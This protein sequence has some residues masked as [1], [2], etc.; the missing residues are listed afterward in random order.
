[1]V[2]QVTFDSAVLTEAVGKA[3]SVAPSKGSAFDK[4]HGIVIEV[5]PDDGQV[6]IRATDLEYYYTEWIQAKSIEGEEVM[7]RLSS[8]AFGGMIA[9]L[10]PGRDV[11]LKQ[12]GQ[13]LEITSGKGLRARLAL[14]D[15]D[16]YP[17]W[18]IFDEDDLVDVSGIG[19][20]VKNVMWAAHDSNDPKLSS[21]HFTGDMVCAT[22][23]YKVSTFPFKLA[24]APEGGITLP[25]SVVKYISNLKGDVRFGWNGHSALIMPDDNTQIKAVALA[26]EYPT[27]FFER[28]NKVEHTH[29]VQINA[30][31]LIHMIDLTSVINE[32]DRV[33][34]RLTLW[35]GRSQIAA[36]TKGELDQMRDIMDVP[37][38]ATHSH[39]VEIRI[40]P[41]YLSDALNA[42]DGLVTMHYCADLEYTNPQSGS[43][44]KK[45]LKFERPGGHMAWA[46][47]IT[48]AG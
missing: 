38:Q 14:G 25:L 46:T 47:P 23:R 28:L 7:W 3:V 13:A 2:T 31:E 36:M 10:K 20:A 4:A 29:K 48:G 17:S 12:D 32:N 39:R 41:N 18:D 34:K 15:T 5:M 22:D 21:V 44:M 19:Q 11:T 43:A 9:K 27:P 24:C 26:E 33:K 40:N 42:G 30:D 1:M 16:S 45:V 8:N 35:L 37:G 6:T